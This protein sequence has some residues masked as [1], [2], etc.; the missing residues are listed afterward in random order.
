MLLKGE[1]LASVQVAY[2]AI[3]IA[4]VIWIGRTVGVLSKRICSVVRR[5]YVPYQRH[6]FHAYSRCRGH[7]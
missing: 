1:A 2:V 4:N 7:D 5:G 6:Y 3:I